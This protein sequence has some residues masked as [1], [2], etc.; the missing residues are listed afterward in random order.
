MVKI[1][2]FS[3]KIE[4]KIDE[5]KIEKLR[6]KLARPGLLVKTRCQFSSGKIDINLG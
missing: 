6:I 4:A 1:A 2:H 3:G 5:E